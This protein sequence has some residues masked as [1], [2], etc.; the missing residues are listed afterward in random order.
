MK[1]GIVIFPSKKIQDY[2][3]SLRRRYD[4][5][6]AL[7]PPHLTLKSPFEATEEEIKN[8]VQKIDAIARNFN[9]VSLNI[10]KIGSFKP[11]NNV[12]YLKVESP[13]DLVSLHSELNSAFEGDQEYNFVPHITIG[14]NMSDDEHSD[15]YGSL[16][17]TKVQF[18]D[19][20]DRLHLLYQLD[21]GSWTVYETFRLRKE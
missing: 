3:N 6:Y 10:T 8:V 7:I 19:T 1:F 4:P 11:V 2:A 14:Q 17:M 15:V 12:I 18:E 21:N 16:R 13:E 5:H 9:P 20:A